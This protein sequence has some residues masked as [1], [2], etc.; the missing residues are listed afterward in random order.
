MGSGGKIWTLR[1]SLKVK[2]VACISLMILAVGASLSWYFLRQTKGM[3]TEELQKKALSVA[4]NL[5]YD[6]KYGILTEDEVILRQLIQ[7]SLQEDSVLLVL[8]ADA[9]GRILAQGA[10][11]DL[12]ATMG[13]EVVELARQHA[14]AMTPHIMTPSLHYHAF[15]TQEVYHAVAAVETTEA[16]PSKSEEQLTSAIL[17]LGRPPAANTPAAAVQ[18]GSVQ[19]ILSLDSMR[20]AIRNT[21]VAGLGL[22]LGTILLGVCLAFVLCD[23]VLAP[24]QAMARAAS[25]IAAGD[26]SQQVPVRGHDEIGLLARTFNHMTTSLDQMT[27]AQQQRLAELSALH[28]IGLIIS[29]TLDLE[30]LLEL[31]LA[32]VI[33]HL[34]YDRAG[35]FLVDTAQQVLTRGKITGAT[36]EIQARVGALEIPLLPLT[37]FPSC[38]LLDDEAVDVDAGNT[39][40]E[41]V[42]Q[43]LVALLG[44]RSLLL[45]PLKVGERVLG[46][47]WV[48]NFRTQ[49]LFTTADQRLLATLANQLAIAIANASAYRQI[50]QLN[51]GLEAKVQERTEALQ[52]QQQ[53]LQEV[54]L[55]LEVANR[56]KSEF[57][58]NMS[59]ELRT[60]LNAII[61]FADVLLEKMFGELNDKQDEYLNDILSSG[62]HLL[63]LINDILDLSKIEAGQM[64][65][66]LGVCHLRALLESS[67]VMVK[68]RALN[69]GIALALDIAD[70]LDAFIG[71]ERKVKQILFNLLSNAIKFTPDQGKV[72]I[73]AHRRDNTV[74]IA[75]WDTGVGIAASDQQLIFQEFYQVGHDLAGKTEGTGLG[76][77][78]TKKFVE[79]H[80][81]T[82]RVDSMLGRGSTFTFT[83]PLDST[84]ASLRFPSVPAENVSE[85]TVLPTTS[86]P[87]VLVIE[88]DAKAA[89]LLRIYLT[90]ANYTVEIARD[91]AEGLAKTRQ[92]GPQAV[93]L[94]ILVPQVDGWAFLHQVKADPATRDVPV[95]VV[96]ILDQKG[97]G[98]ALGAAEYLVKPVQKGELLRTLATLQMGA[99]ARTSAARVL[100]IDDDPKA[101]EILA[102]L[103]QAEGFDVL[104][105]Y[106]G[107]T[108]LTLAETA[109][110]ALV[111]LDLL[112]PG[113]HGY[114]VLDRLKQS[115]VTQQV[116]VIIFT[117]KQ[118]TAEDRQRL[119]GRLTWWAQKDGGSEKEVAAI[120]KA[121]LQ[122]TLG[123]QGAPC[124]EQSF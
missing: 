20:A 109:Q 49:R 76:L 59:H 97:K 62:H 2:A 67:L 96:S 19:V 82:L 16:T 90:E 117:I 56:H 30:R 115:P 54:N 110:P 120:V 102:A 104:R 122:R 68:E 25:R 65:L 29:A 116:P 46:V 88:D 40:Q 87:L 50:E 14:M 28:D 103:L 71:D 77:T 7:G 107:Q 100:V 72:G 105:A 42:Y 34:R 39:G 99:R 81:G 13:P 111:I 75:V 51:T 85:H 53:Q 58:A 36:A 21:S 27:Q 83:L 22:T 101:V 35:V 63:S 80:G 57:L 44:V 3:L 31:G 113:M 78:L 61:G 60:P 118:R 37:A 47:L 52:S 1:T 48:D 112:M 15:G 89:D 17:M 38:V 98:L 106:D 23:Y 73:T 8:I 45:L 95:V 69:H 70:E 121:A 11:P 86:G 123:E 32:A 93:I 12:A 43:P 84:A 74:E 64:E 79:L 9:E 94:D 18:R 114:E 10:R 4:Q 24:V 124:L 119:Q 5:A 41:R 92:L 91:G 55:R 66:E 6:S 26:L 33:Q 108:G